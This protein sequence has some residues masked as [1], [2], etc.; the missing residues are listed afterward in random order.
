MPVE[1]VVKV[2]KAVAEKVPE[3]GVALCRLRIKEDILHP[4]DYY[5]EDVF[6][7]TAIRS[8]YTAKG[9]EAR[10]VEFIRRFA[11]GNKGKKKL[12]EM[13]KKEFGVV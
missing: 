4:H 1:L 10:R 6:L 7:L 5:S 8:I 2:E 3:E 12:I 13:V 9:N 11:V